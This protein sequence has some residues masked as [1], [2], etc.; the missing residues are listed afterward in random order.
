MA[1]SVAEQ[2]GTADLVIGLVP[3]VYDAEAVEGAI[4]RIVEFTPPLRTIL[5]HPPYTP[6]GTAPPVLGTQWQLM[7]NPQLGQDA[8]PLAQTLGDSF[9][10]IFDVTRKM[11][12]RACAVVASDLST[13]TADW[14]NRL[15]GPAVNEKFDLVAPCFAR[16]PF[17][18]LINRAI[19]Y[20]L[21]RALYGKRVRNP[22][23]PDFGISTALLDRIAG[24][25]RTRF[26][27]VVSLT[28]EAVTSGMRVCQV[29]LGPRL[30]ARPDWTNLSSLLAQVLGPLFLDVERYAP[31][32]QRARGSQPITEFGP[33]MFAPVP[34]SAVDVSR[35]IESFQLGTR[36]LTEIWGMILPPSTLVELRGLARHESAGFRMPD[37]T[38]ARIVYDFALGHR[39]RTISRDQLLRAITP[40]YLGWVASYA[41]E[42]ENATP[43]TVEERLEKLCVAYE[44][45]KPYFVARWRWPDRFNP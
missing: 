33:P 40:I 20:P 34:E 37:E 12:A 10:A 6:N 35:L 23:G 9:R 7:G 29:H 5:V 18:G 26:H 45:T 30:Y 1:D 15:L 2:I 36:N 17:E 28:A 27:P 41:L 25:P 44:N 4:L 21:V 42:L 3:A 38:W 19:L 16:H 14:V 39:L 31:H 8:K 32:W 11:G 13:V 24:V 43:E 22:L